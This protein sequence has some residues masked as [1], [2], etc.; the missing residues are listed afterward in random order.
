MHARFPSHPGPIDLNSLP[1]PVSCSCSC[2]CLQAPFYLVVE[3][4]GSN[5]AHDGEKLEQF[6]ED[7]MGAGLVLGEGR[8][9][10]AVL[11][12]GRPGAG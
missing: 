5:A 11:A 1:S 9:V 3:T 10:P 4:S 8:A 2:R 6:L 7:A 12:G